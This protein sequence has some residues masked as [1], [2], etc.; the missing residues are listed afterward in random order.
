M[1]WQAISYEYY[2]A[3]ALSLGDGGAD[4]DVPVIEV[5]LD[6][7]RRKERRGLDVF[8]EFCAFG[9][10]GEASCSPLAAVVVIE[11]KAPP[12]R[13]RRILR[14]VD[15]VVVSAL[16]LEACIDIF[17]SEVEAALLSEAGTGV[18]GFARLADVILEVASLS[19]FDVFLAVA[20]GGAGA[21]GL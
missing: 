9:R 21:I 16:M 14:P 6:D 20:S 2:R 11:G 19:A 17:V 18:T 10:E 8:L 7:W 5:D 15:G 3:T 1:D 13:G 12:I 4:N